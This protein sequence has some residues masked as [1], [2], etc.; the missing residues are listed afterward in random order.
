MVLGLSLVLLHSA[1]GGGGE[2]G[3]R[4]EFSA[5]RSDEVTT[6]LHQLN[7]KKDSLKQLE[8]DLYKPLQSFSPK[9]SL[10]GVAPRPVRPPPRAAT[11]NKRVKDLL[12]RRK[13]WVFMNPDDLVNAPT[14]EDMLKNHEFGAEGDDK[15]EL[16]PVQSFYH[17]LANKHTGK[18]VPASAGSEELFGKESRKTEQRES[19]REEDSSLP[20]G[21][22][23]SAEKLKRMFQREEV[24]DGFSRG[25]GRGSMEDTFGLALKEPTL[26]EIKERTKFM[27]DYR[28]E[29][30]PSWRP[31]VQGVPEN[32]L[33]AVPNPLAPP[34]AKPPVNLPTIASTPSTH[35]V[36]DAQADVLS[37]RLGPQ[38]LPDL[39]LQAVGQTRPADLFPKIET[40]RVLAPPPSFEVPK[41]SFR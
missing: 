30:D 2:R 17:R 21:I 24:V 13:N 41:R 40:T 37:P 33:T 5:P 26:E 20:S 10:D 19:A 27:T 3:R 22:K 35:N 25:I 39:N 34:T 16:A 8:E 14:L 38:P 31:L 11:E 36:L 7:S 4:I 18:D 15:K 29:A 28:A 23:E 9:G 12:E 6:N 32:P 1:R